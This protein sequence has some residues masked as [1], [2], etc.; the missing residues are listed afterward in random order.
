MLKI[1]RSDG[2]LATAE[3]LWVKPVDRELWYMLNSVG[4]QTA[5]VEVSG[6]FAHW[7]AEV[8]LGAAIKTPMVKQAVD[9]LQEALE[10]VL[11]DEST[12]K[13]LSSAA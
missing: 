1:A 8:K 5:V 13:W 2:V 9:A 10:N 3:F 7:L 6:C 4:R 12:I 11:F